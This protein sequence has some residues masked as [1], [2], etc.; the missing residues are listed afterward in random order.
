MPRANLTA[1]LLTRADLSGANLTLAAL[2]GAVLRGTKLF[3][4]NLDG[5][6]LQDRPWRD[7]DLLGAF[8]DIHT[9]WPAGFDPHAHGAILVTAPPKE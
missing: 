1:A 3:G 9:R 5:V 2:G 8:Y 4:A 6:W 7:A